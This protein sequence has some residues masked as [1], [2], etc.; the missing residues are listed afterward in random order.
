MVPCINPQYRFINQCLKLS[1]KA[2]LGIPK[3]VRLLSVPI[4]AVISDGTLRSPIF[5]RHAK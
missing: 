3:K 4:M 2:D 1:P 5:K